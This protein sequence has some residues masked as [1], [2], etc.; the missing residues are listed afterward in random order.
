MMSRSSESIKWIQD[1]L[2]DIADH[3]EEAFS[4]V[5]LRRRQKNVNSSDNAASAQ[6]DHKIADG[7]HAIS[8]ALGTYW[9]R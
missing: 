9:V 5:E 6:F 8:A 1:G 4:P 2:L 7:L 3:Y